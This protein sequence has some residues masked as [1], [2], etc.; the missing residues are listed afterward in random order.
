M[1]PA[2]RRFAPTTVRQDWNGVRQDWNGVR[3]DWNGVRYGLEQVSDISG[4]RKLG[5]SRALAA[6]FHD[7]RNAR[8]GEHSLP[9][10]LAQRLYGLTLGCEYL[11]DHATSR[12]D[13]LLATA[14]DKADPLGLDR[15]TPARYGAALA[16]PATLNRLE[17]SHNKTTR[18]HKLAHDPVA[19]EQCLL[20]LG[21]RGLPKHAREVVLDLDAMGHLIHGTRAG[22]HFSADVT[23]GIVTCRCGRNCARP[24]KTARRAPCRRG[25]C[26]IGVDTASRRHGSGCQKAE[27]QRISRVAALD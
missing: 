21:V 25:D 1:T 12:R 8:F 16:A 22:R 19:V 9:Q 3:Q 7:P 5:L 23:T 20:T 27:F 15:L 6:G 10:L 14:C 13:P 4:I 18:C 2:A 24:I 17:L 11:H 26:S